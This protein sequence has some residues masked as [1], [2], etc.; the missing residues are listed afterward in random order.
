MDR[1]GKI[2]RDSDP[3]RERLSQMDALAEQGGGAERV[4]KQH[5][6]GKLTARERLELLLDRGSFTE[7]D[8]FVTHRAHDFGMAGKKVL[9]DGVVTGYGT[10]DGRQVFVF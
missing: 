2:E 9:G 3:A 5:E 4:A 6:A 10:I 7:L 8:K 1:S